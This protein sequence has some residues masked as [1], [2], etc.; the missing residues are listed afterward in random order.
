[1][2]ILSFVL[3]TFLFTTQTVFAQ[4]IPKEHFIPFDP[5][6]GYDAGSLAVINKSG[7]ASP[8]FNLSWFKARV[9][10]EIYDTTS[11]S[12]GDISDNR[13]RQKQLEAAIQ[14]N[15]DIKDVAASLKGNLSRLDRVS[16]EGD[17]GKRIYLKHGTAAINQA[18]QKLTIEDLLTIQEK[19]TDKGDLYLITEVIKYASGRQTIEWVKEVEG[20]FQA[21][22]KEIISGNSKG[23]W[24]SNKILVVDYNS[25]ITAGYLAVNFEKYLSSKVKAL[26]KERKK[27]GQI[28]VG[29][30]QGEAIYTNGDRF[31][32]VYSISKP[33]DNQGVL[34]IDVTSQGNTLA[35]TSR[36]KYTPIKDKWIEIPENDLD[37]KNVELTITEESIDG[38]NYD[39]N[40]PGCP[41]QN[42]VHLRRRQLSAGKQLIMINTYDKEDVFSLLYGK[43]NRPYFVQ[44]YNLGKVEIYEFSPGKYTFINK[45]ATDREIRRYRTDLGNFAGNMGPFDFKQHCPHF[46]FKESLIDEQRSD[47]DD[48]ITRPERRTF[49]YKTCQ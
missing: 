34:K 44:D 3:S 8:A 19:I 40:L 27:T 6:G 17:S 2:K 18:L 43:G 30:W 29:I 11:I 21:Q 15:K 13:K 48:G 26:I 1:M 14:T 39:C 46:K 23:A 28:G 10:S 36:F 47:T 7:V 38:F 41:S 42:T 12:V 16:F 45:L 22:V 32:V 4:E 20:G 35:Q 9:S 49:K 37:K 5:L 31:D 33:A 25:N 24:Q